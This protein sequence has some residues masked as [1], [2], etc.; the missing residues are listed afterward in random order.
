MIIIGKGGHARAIQYLWSTAQWGNINIKC[1]DWFPGD[2]QWALRNEMYIIG[3]G[4]NAIRKEIS[5]YLHG[6]TN[7][8]YG[9]HFTDD[10]GEGT[11]F[12]PGSIIMPGCRIG[13][14]C[15]IN[16]RAS[17]DHDCIL[18]NYVSIAPGATICGGVHIGEGA[19]IGAGAVV[20]QG[21]TIK[22]WEKIPAGAVVKC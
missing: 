14:H 5:K 9:E 22:P 6:Y 19:S 16:T 1:F 4:D 12:M 3:I 11:V 13:K 21:V 20:V 18:E 2:N 15:I 7:L 10:V 8:W 17:V